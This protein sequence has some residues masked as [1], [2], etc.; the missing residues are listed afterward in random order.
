MGLGA[1]GLGENCL[2]AAPECQTRRI[3][4]GVHGGSH[5]VRVILAVVA[6][7]E[8]CTEFRFSF[9]VR[10]GKLITFL[11]LSELVTERV[12]IQVRHGL[13]FQFSFRTAKFSR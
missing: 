9:G 8:I 5:A 1:A 12:S 6:I 2:P 13:A 7:W 3:S 10:F 4:G 11:R